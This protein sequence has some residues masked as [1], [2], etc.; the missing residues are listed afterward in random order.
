MKATIIF[1]NGGGV[2]LQLDGS[3]A[4]YYDSNM[5]QAAEDYR[6]YMQDGNTDGWDGHEL[7]SLELEPAMDD[8]R[9][10]G[11]TV[12]DQDDIAKAVADPDYDTGWHNVRDFIEALR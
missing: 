11:Y 9:N 3:W 7:E 1:D 2:T 12:F 6:T 4:H 5:E 10:G 8:I